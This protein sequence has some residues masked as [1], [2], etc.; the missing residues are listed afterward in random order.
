MA[1]DVAVL[2]REPGGSTV[3][4]GKDEVL[5]RVPPVQERLPPSYPAFSALRV[6]APVPLPAPVQWFC[7]G[8]LTE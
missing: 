3:L 4:T 7:G 5:P 6:L 2:A 8:F 1:V